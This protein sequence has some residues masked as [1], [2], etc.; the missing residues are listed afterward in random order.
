ML[1]NCIKI[2]ALAITFEK[3]TLPMEISFGKTSRLSRGS[4]DESFAASTRGGGKSA[5]PVR[6]EGGG[7][8]KNITAHRAVQTPQ[9]ALPVRLFSDGVGIRRANSKRKHNIIAPR[10]TRT[11]YERFYAVHGVTVC[12]F[13]FPRHTR[14]P[15]HTPA[16]RSQKQ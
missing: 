7:A 1:K 13:V 8:L 2:R 5:L 12:D 14:C 3:N 16:H 4:V 11:R 15:S 6:P 10:P 9:S